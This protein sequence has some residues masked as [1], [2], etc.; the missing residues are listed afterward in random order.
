MSARRTRPVDIS[1]WGDEPPRWIRLLAAEVEASNRQLAGQRIGMSRST[2]ALALANRYPSPSTAGVERRV[3]AALDGLECPAQGKTISSQQCRAF[4]ERP[5]P[6][7]NPMAM[8]NWRIC[9]A[10]P[11]N[12]DCP[13]GGE[14]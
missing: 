11:H 2:V 7:H 10:C 8:R 3:L 13:C 1:A 4:R 12:P 9:Q 14:Q 5:V 6:T